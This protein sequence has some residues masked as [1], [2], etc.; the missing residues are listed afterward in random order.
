MLDFNDKMHQNRFRIPRPRWGSLQLDLRGLLLRG[1]KGNGQEGR[2]G[3]GRGGEGREGRGGALDLSASSFC[4]EGKG[5]KG[6]RRGREARKGERRG[7]GREGKGPSPLEKNPGAA[8][9]THTLSDPR[10]WIWT[11]QTQP[12][13]S[14]RVWV[15]A[16][17][18]KKISARF[19]RILRLYR[20]RHNGFIHAWW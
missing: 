6:K 3:E 8:T 11:V 9:G 1:G 20:D 10:G 14:D 2:G 18:Q 17:F 5:G 7:K 13:G 16:S 4:G 12:R 19:C 15:I